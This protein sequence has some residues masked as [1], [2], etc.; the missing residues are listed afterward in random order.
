MTQLSLAV[1]A[2]DPPADVRAAVRAW[3]DEHVPA[4]WL[5]AART[6]D[7]ETLRR[8]R[9]REVYVN[10]YPTLGATGLITPTWP[11]EYGGLGL[12]RDLAGVIEEEL[13][14]AQLPKLNVLGLGL[15]A[16]TIMRWGTSQQK[17][18]L[19]PKIAT[20]EETWCQLFSEPGAGSDL[21]SLAT[22][23]KRDVDD[24][25][26]SG[27]KTWT[28]F[29][30]VA[31]RG[32]LLARTAPDRPKHQGLTYFVADLEAPGV[33][34]RPLRQMTGDAE[35]SEV[36]FDNVVLPD[37]ARLGE[38]NAGWAVARTTLMSERVTISGVGSGFRDRLSGRSIDR[39]IERASADGPV[40]PVQADQLVRLWMESRAL[41]WTNRRVANVRSFGGEVGPEGSV[42]KLFQSEHNQRLQ[43]TVS[44]M[45]GPRGVAFR[46]D[47]RDAAT[48]TYGFLRSRADTIAGGTSEVMRDLLAERVLGLPREPAVDRDIPWRDVKRNG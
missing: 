46:P 5:R 26:I 28:S 30:D 31:K 15:A 27:Q 18:D 47:D 16:P 40:D 32:M 1:S 23:A 14:E 3:L 42:G 13:R 41:H 25:I 10:W 37:S 2:Q 36:F 39:L 48:A 11:R 35:F 9:P 45:L 38:V 34:V 20:N 22:R 29:G 33:T 19:L 8:V 43:R 21:S 7:M 4:E 44:E 12:D 6:G 17:K 24:W